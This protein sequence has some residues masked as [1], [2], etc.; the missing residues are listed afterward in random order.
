[1]AYRILVSGSRNG[2]D[3]EPFAAVLGTYV[4]LGLTYEG[5]VV[6]IHGAA[7]GVDAMCDAWEDSYPGVT[8][9][10]YPANW[11]EHG[12]SAGPRRNQVMLDTDP[13]I[14]LAFKKNFNMKLDNGGTEHMIK[15][16]AKAG[17]PHLIITGV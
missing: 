14:V 17:V 2:F 4:E 15:I 7:K 1:M 8:I 11:A 16:A 6:I 10:R 13:D 5:E 3:P 12:R 9:E